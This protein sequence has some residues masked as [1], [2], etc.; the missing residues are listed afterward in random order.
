MNSVFDNEY[1]QALADSLYNQSEREKSVVQYKKA[2]LTCPDKS[3]AYYDLGFIL[4]QE[5]RYHE[6]IRY[7]KKAALLQPYSSRVYRSWGVALYW[8]GNYQEAEVKLEE[9]RRIYSSCTET[10]YWLGE[11]LL[12]F[13]QYDEVIAI[14]ERVERMDLNNLKIYRPWIAAMLDLGKIKEAKSLLV[15]L[16]KKNPQSHRTYFY[17]GIVFEYKGM[18]EEAIECYKKAFEINPTFDWALNNWGYVLVT[19]GEYDNAIEKFNKVLQMNNGE[20]RT[21]LNLSIV[22]ELQ[23][24]NTEAREVLKRGLEGQKDN[25][26]FDKQ[27]FIT[28]IQEE[29]ERINERVGKDEIKESEKVKLK[30]LEFAING[31]KNDGQELEILDSVASG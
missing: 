23:N 4:S 6:A 26:G 10:D 24:K 21:F 18:F 22:Y 13:S 2:I 17:I 15:N 29:I 8:L 16:K 25:K 30:A 28:E 27:V 5:K 11:V 20:F 19:L 7:F 31:L 14:C 12:K 1:Y 3:R 9:A